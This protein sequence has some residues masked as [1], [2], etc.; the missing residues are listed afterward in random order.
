VSS[1]DGGVGGVDAVYVRLAYALC[2][3]AI[4][5]DQTKR[6]FE[7]VLFG[8][9]VLELVFGFCALDAL[10]FHHLVRLNRAITN[11]RVSRT[12][13]QQ[14][15]KRVRKITDFL[16]QRLAEVLEFALEFALLA[17]DLFRLAF[18]VQELRA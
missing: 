18:L 12:K 8:V 6:S 17:H 2:P 13:A 7:G 10:N 1:G 15:G 11:E 3:H 9:H 16:E 14:R 4:F 5:L